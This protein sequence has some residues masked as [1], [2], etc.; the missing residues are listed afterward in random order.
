[1]LTANNDLAEHRA[2]MTPAIGYYRHY[3][4][5]HYQLIS[6]AKHSES[7]EQL[8]IYRCLYGDFSIWARP[9]EMFLANVCLPDGQIVPRFQLVDLDQATTATL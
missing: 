4:G 3:K 7:G 5:Q 6:T 2:L 1:M 8:A 9:L